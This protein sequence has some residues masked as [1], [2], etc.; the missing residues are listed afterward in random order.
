M[1]DPVSLKGSQP[2]QRCYT[3]HEYLIARDGLGV[4]SILRHDCRRM[5]LKRNYKFYMYED[6]AK[7]HAPAAEQSAE[8][9]LQAHVPLPGQPLH[10]SML[11]CCERR[12][13]RCPEAKLIRSIFLSSGQ[14]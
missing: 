2:P 9:A 11:H 3:W 4:L 10:V 14:R 13:T 8:A 6:S 1:R 12:I 7:G 5:R